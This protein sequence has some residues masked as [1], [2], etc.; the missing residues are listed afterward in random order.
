MP[1]GTTNVEISGLPLSRVPVR[2]VI[3]T[4]EVMS[5]PELVMN[6]LLPLSTQ[7]SP[8][9]TARVRM[10]SASE[11]ES[12][13][14]RPNAASAWPE[15]RSGSQR[16]FCSVVPHS[17]IG[18]APSPTAASR[19]TPSDWSTRPISSTAMHRLVKSPAP[20]YSSGPF[21]PNSPNWPIC[22]T[23]SSGSACSTFQRSTCGASCSAANSATAARKS[24]CS[25]LSAYG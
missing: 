15:S 10:A 2:A 19:V 21:R 25:S 7:L 1:R 16:C 12:A 14:V 11:P 17:A 8:S 5:V 23:A 20:P 4:S 6:C 9:R 3:R 18:W 22:L 24:S 13:S